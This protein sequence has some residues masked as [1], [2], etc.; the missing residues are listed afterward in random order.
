MVIPL[1][2]MYERLPLSETENISEI[3]CWKIIAGQLQ[4]HISFYSYLKWRTQVG[5]TGWTTKHCAC[6]TREFLCNW[7]TRSF[8]GRTRKFAYKL[9]FKLFKTVITL[10][11]TKAHFKSSQSAV[12][13]SRCLVEASN[14]YV[15]VAAG[16][17]LSSHCLAMG[18]SSSSAIPAFR[19]RVTV[20]T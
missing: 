14:N 10:Q 17:C 6:D 5:F 8:W 7:V 18:V 19:R 1:L 4:K 3:S 11:I 16:T 2:V 13:N 20:R 12:F 15:F 9:T